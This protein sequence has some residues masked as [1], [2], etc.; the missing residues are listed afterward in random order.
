M[1]KVKHEAQVD[2]LLAKLKESLMAPNHGDGASWPSITPEELNAMDDLF[3]EA[4]RLKW[5]ED[6]DGDRPVRLLMVARR[7]CRLLYTLVRHSDDAPSEKQETVLLNNIRTLSSGVAAHA[8]ELDMAH[9]QLDALLSERACRTAVVP[10]VQVEYLR[11][12][13]WEDTE[14]KR[15]VAVSLHQSAADADAF[16]PPEGMTKRRQTPVWVFPRTHANPEGNFAQFRN[17]L[18]SMTDEVMPQFSKL[19]K[20]DFRVSFSDPR[21]GQGA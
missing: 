17:L 19:N 9:R 14:L 20:A 6:C 13:V 4:M 12:K 18:K 1:N 5:A 3:E 2:A 7:D 10:M 16:S 11:P 15:E 21:K 8:N